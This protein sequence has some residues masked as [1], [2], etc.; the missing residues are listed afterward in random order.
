MSWTTESTRTVPVTVKGIPYRVDENDD[1]TATVK[2][3]AEDAG[4]RK[5]HVLIDGRNI[6]PEDAP[7]TFH[8]VSRVE[9][10][11]YDKAG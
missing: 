7:E 1:F 10:F 8:G 3:L 9:I 5:F 6:D 4:I 11:P 2:R